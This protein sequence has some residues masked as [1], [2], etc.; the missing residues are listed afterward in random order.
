MTQS[1]HSTDIFSYLVTED[2]FPHDINELWSIRHNGVASMSKLICSFKI[3]PSWHWKN[4]MNIGGAWL[5]LG[6]SSQSCTLLT[7]LSIQ[8]SHSK[9]LLHTVSY[10]SHMLKLCLMNAFGLPAYRRK[11]SCSSQ[12]AY[13]G[14]KDKVS[15]TQSLHLSQYIQH[16]PVFQ[17]TSFPIMPKSVCRWTYYNV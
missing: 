10:L 12:N 16:F 1:I 13:H 8:H 17:C 14:T 2:C 6:K 4:L 15:L 3:A 11:S 7:L 9:W 5:R